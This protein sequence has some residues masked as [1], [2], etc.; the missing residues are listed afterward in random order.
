MFVIIILLFPLYLNLVASA[1]TNACSP[2]STH[3]QTLDSC[4]C[5]YEVQKFLHCNEY[6]YIDAVRDCACVTYNED[7]DEIS[8]GHCIYGCNRYVNTSDNDK[9]KGYSFI[10]ADQHKWNQLLCDSPFQRTSIL[11]GSCFNGSHPLAYSFD[12]RCITCIN[13]NK[14]IW[15][16]L[17]WAFL[18]LTVFYIVFLL[19]QINILSSPLFGFVIYS[20]IFS[21]SMFIKVFIA[22]KNNEAHYANYIK[23]IEMFYGIWNLD[24][25]RTFNHQL[26]LNI[27]TLTN[28]FLDFIIAIYPLLLLAVT[29]VLILLYDNKYRFVIVI[30][31]PFQH[32][33]LFF[34]KNCSIRTSIVHSFATFIFLSNVKLLSTCF[35]ILI[36]VDVYQFKSLQN[37]TIKHLRQVYSDAT[38]E[39]FGP[40]HLPY[41]IVALLVFFVFGFLPVLILFLYPFKHFQYFVSKCPSR[42][43]LSLN[44]FVDSFQG[45]YKDGTRPGCKDYRLVS[46]LPFIFRWLILIIYALLLNVSCFPLVTIIAVITSI[47][48]I[49]FDPLQKHFYSITYY[50]IVLLIISGIC[51]ISASCTY[52]IPFTESTMPLL[53]F[54]SIVFCVV[55]VL[56]LFILLWNI[57]RFFCKCEYTATFMKFI[58]DGKTLLAFHRRYS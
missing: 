9:V 44:T 56:P 55:I 12:V 24:F 50:F 7:T 5:P 8:V 49:V 36:P 35:D 18:P 25:F 22:D 32:F 15:K 1:K 16:Y 40:K 53:Y 33:F 52:T 3:N 27:G 45:C 39:Y 47:F 41:A 54:F 37:S 29:Y 46:V 23:T 14:D 58:K 31:K 26:C 19:L 17:L 21:Q 20:Q 43:I 51:C 57:L 34:E 28:I 42:L 10:G 11:C 48:F 6:G 38:L 13:A 4:A 2:Y 30:L